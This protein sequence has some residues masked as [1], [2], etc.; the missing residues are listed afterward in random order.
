MLVYLEDGYTIIK[1]LK[2]KGYSSNKIRKE[3]LIPEG[4]M[5]SLRR[6]QMV[7]TKT[8]GTLC[9]LLDVPVENLICNVKK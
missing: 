9:D 5:T 2:E 3:H 4:T 7:S 1:K 8:L 6:N